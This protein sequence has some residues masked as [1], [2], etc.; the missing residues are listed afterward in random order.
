[1]TVTLAV[2]P[3]LVVA[4]RTALRTQVEAAIAAG[5]DVELD[6][7]STGYVDTAAIGMLLRLSRQA[8]EAGHRVTLA[9]VTAETREF[10]RHIG[11]LRILELADA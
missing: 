7:S 10:F 5:H 8:K 4:N 2:A 11:V 1:M 3:A 9:G 6:L